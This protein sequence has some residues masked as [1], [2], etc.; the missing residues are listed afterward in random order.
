MKRAVLQRQICPHGDPRLAILVE[1]LERR[2]KPKEGSCGNGRADGDVLGE[3]AQ[4]VA[5]QDRIVVH[6]RLWSRDLD[7]DYD[8]DDDDDVMP[9]TRPSRP[10]H[11]PTWGWRRPARSGEQAG[12]G[13]GIP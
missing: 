10:C 1:Q 5:G 9:M 2:H 6:H 11:C 3:G 4:V 13:K 8:Y 7:N 12:G